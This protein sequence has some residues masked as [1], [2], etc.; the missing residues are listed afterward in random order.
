MEYGITLP[1]LDTE[2]FAIAPDVT[3]PH[4]AGQDV[5]VTFDSSGIAVVRPE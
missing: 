5:H 1:G 2:L 4:I 3:T